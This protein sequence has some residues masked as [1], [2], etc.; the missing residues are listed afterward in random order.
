MRRADGN[1]SREEGD[2][3]NRGK[4]Y[5]GGRRRHSI[6]GNRAAITVHGAILTDKIEAE[7]ELPFLERRI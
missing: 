4:R 3:D 5:R 1:G 6:E 7:M 2:G